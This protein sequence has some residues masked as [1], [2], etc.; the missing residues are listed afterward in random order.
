M[1]NKNNN[2]NPVKLKKRP[3]LNIGLVI[4]IVVCLYI[5][6]S[7]LY[8]FTKNHL[9]LYE[10][11]ETEFAQ[12][13]VV[14]GIIIRNEE[15]FYTETAGYIYFFNENGSRVKKDSY[16]YALDENKDNYDKL[17]NTDIDSQFTELDTVGIKRKITSF[18]EEYDNN[19]FST[20]YDYNDSLLNT[21]YELSN[22]YIIKNVEDIISNNNISN[23]FHSY[24]AEKSGIVSYWNNS[25]NGLTLNDIT[26]EMFDENFDAS[27]SVSNSDIKGK[28]E[29]VYTLI[30]DEDWYVVAM[31]NKD[32]YDAVKDKSKIEIII[33]YDNFKIS[34]PITSYE[35]DGYYYIKLSF[36]QYMVKYIEFHEIEIELKWQ[37]SEGYK[38]PNTAITEKEFF[39]IPD[40]FFTYGGDSNNIGLVKESIDKETGEATY[41]FIECDIY[42]KNENYTYIDAAEFQKGDIIISTDNEYFTIGI[43]SKL[44]GVYNVNKGYAVFRRIEKLYQNDDYCIIRMDTTYGISLYDHIALDSST[45]IDLGIIY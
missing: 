23:T 39:L 20:I 25:L 12:D 14:K 32:Q 24:K 9:S 13:N 11:Q 30:Y 5:G 36:N 26:P 27:S 43:T 6:I 37:T 3:S 28:N 19:N 18:R 16:V 31:V 10:V 2:T 15:V 44:T 33:K 21:I 40:Y 1:E 17:V 41:T 29:A 45:V 4:F 7:F 38:I 34:V 42:Y 35:S 8:Y 22:S